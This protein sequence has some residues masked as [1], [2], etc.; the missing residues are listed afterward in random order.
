V[1]LLE[2]SNHI[3]HCLRTL[4]AQLAVVHME[5]DS[6]LMAIDH[7]VGHTRVVLLGGIKL[8]P[9]VSKTFTKLP[10]VQ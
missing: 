3:I 2:P 10:V 9:I 4:V 5:A 1:L 8:G 6:H 7:L